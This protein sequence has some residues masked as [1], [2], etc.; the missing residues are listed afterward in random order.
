MRMQAW[1]RMRPMSTHLDCEAERVDEAVVEIFK[2][3]FSI[4]LRL[5]ANERHLSGHAIPA[6]I[7]RWK[8]VRADGGGIR[9]LHPPA[10]SLPF[11]P[12]T[13]MQ[14]A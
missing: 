5:E 8:V 12:R 10:N 3:G 11:C 13:C 9:E 6:S 4:A 14:A 7:W 2:G 1:M